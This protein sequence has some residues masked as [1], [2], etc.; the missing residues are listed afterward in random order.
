MRMRQLIGVV[1]RKI[2]THAARQHRATFPLAPTSPTHLPAYLT[3]TPPAHCTRV[4]P[5]WRSSRTRQFGHVGM[6]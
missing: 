1:A 6:H 4:R 2:G 5:V 3:S